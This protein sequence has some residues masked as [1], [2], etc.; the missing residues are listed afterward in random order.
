LRNEREAMIAEFQQERNELLEEIASLREENSKYLDTIV[1]H[2]KENAEQNLNNRFGSLP[3]QSQ[4]YISRKFHPP[5]KSSETSFNS[6]GYELP[7]Q[8]ANYDSFAGNDTLQQPL[9]V[10]NNVMNPANVYIG[11]TAVR[12]LTLKQMKD[13]IEEIYTS[14]AKY[15]Q[16]CLEAKLPR[17]TMEQHM[18]TYLNQ[19]YGLKNLIIEWATAIINGIKKFSIEDN[20]VAV[21]GKILRNECDEEFRFVQGQVKV[22]ISEL[23]RV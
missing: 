3:S 11:Q 6:K 4:E 7:P 5:L 10:S 1:R 19:K 14:K 13:V 21:F 22:T 18:Y 15:D 8:K 23:L 9:K 16:R 12:A 20:D 17:E 2:S